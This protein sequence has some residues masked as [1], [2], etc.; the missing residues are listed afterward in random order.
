[1]NIVQRSTM[2]YTPKVV[3]RQERR[4]DLFA[5]YL[6]MCVTNA[7]DPTLNF[8]RI[9][10]FEDVTLPDPNNLHEIRPDS[11]GGTPLTI[12]GTNKYGAPDLVVTNARGSYAS[13]GTAFDGEYSG[14][15]LFSCIFGH[16][17]VYNALWGNSNQTVLNVPSASGRIEF[18]TH[19][20]RIAL[21]SAQGGLSLGQVAVTNGVI[22]H[23]ATPEPTPSQLGPNGAAL[24][25]SNGTVYLYLSTDGKMITTRK[26]LAP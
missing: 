23:P 13:L 26:L 17:Y 14:L 7:G 1:M 18:R 4:V 21:L 6:S 22:L 10:R 8:A 2:Y 24:W 11:R 25:N 12:Y 19:G 9:L 3:P 20:E 5:S 16:S 15:Q